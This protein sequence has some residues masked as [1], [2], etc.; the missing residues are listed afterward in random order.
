MGTTHLQYLRS[1]NKIG[2][3]GKQPHARPSP[4][5]CGHPSLFC[6]LYLYYF[7]S[8]LPFFCPPL[9]Q[10]Y[11][12]WL[13]RWFLCLLCQ[14]S[15]LCLLCMP[16][17]QP[18]KWKQINEELQWKLSVLLWELKVLL[19]KSRVKLLC[20]IGTKPPTAQWSWI[21]CMVAINQHKLRYCYNYFY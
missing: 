2:H 18:G 9:T 21:F 13:S 20:L 7:C 3:R 15:V 11:W 19:D 17:G 4:W 12:L 6:L 8:L 10:H 1:S 16:S 14:D 5:I